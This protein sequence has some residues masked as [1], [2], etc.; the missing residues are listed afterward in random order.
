MTT[1]SPDNWEKN[2]KNFLDVFLSEID[3]D[4]KRRAKLFNIEY[5]SK[6][7]IPAFTHSSWDPNLD[8]NYEFLELEGDR[9]LG[10]LFISYL[11]KRFKG[12]DQA[13]ASFL[14][15]KFLK[16]TSLSEISSKLGLA[17]MVRMK[18]NLSIHI[19]EDIFESFFGALYL[20][21]ENIKIGLGIFYATAM[22][23]HIFG[24]IKI[25]PDLIRDAKT[26]VKEI[27]EKMAWKNQQEVSSQDSNR[28]WT[29][30]V[31][32][33][34]EALQ[35][36]I[37]N[38]QNKRAPKSELG[39]G[40]SVQK[41]LASN[42]AYENTLEI[43]TSLGITPEFADRV[44]IQ[45]EF[46]SPQLTPYWPKIKARMAKDGIVTLMFAKKI[47]GVKIKFV[48][49]LGLIPDETK[50][51]G[52]KVILVSMQGTTEDDTQLKINA[53]IKYAST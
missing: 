36:F 27:F 4:Q 44:K 18:V 48:Q 16:K 43:L 23:T 26:Q 28:V 14:S 3:K 1:I 35:W 19:R 41:I 22:V 8:K 13:Q 2:L 45:R 11:K 39:S 6:Y 33:T 31:Y 10:L 52:K 12:I 51:G 24:Q 25:D 9:L 47:Q 46:G 38:S 53:L 21:G 7:W 17:E 42:Q 34:E 15:S 40:T 30:T 29:I 20:V 49:L 32:F 37:A 50:P 5:M